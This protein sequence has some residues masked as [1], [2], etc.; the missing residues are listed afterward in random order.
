M[1]RKV[2]QQAEGVLH[3]GITR[4]VRQNFATLSTQ[5]LFGPARDQGVEG[6][7]GALFQAFEF[8]TT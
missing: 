4:L 3:N 1:H 2:E 7:L 5:F 8:S 6:D